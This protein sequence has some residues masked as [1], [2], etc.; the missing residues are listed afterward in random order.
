MSDNNDQDKALEGDVVMEGNPM[1]NMKQPGGFDISQFIKPGD[2]E[3]G[4]TV[5]TP[6]QMKLLKEQLKGQ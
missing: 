6:E 5:L 3:A 4:K 1:D 2:I